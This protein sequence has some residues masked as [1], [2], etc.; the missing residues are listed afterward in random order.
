MLIYHYTDEQGLTGII[1]NKSI[2][3]TDIR[4]LND[5]MEFHSGI[6]SLTKICNDMIKICKEKDD[7]IYKNA[8]D[9]YKVINTFIRNNLENRNIYITSFTKS[10]DNLRQWMSYCPKNSGYA[11]AIN[12][13]KIL[14]I[15][16]K[17]QCKNIVFRLEDVDY[18]KES[19]YKM[20][21]LDSLIKEITKNFN[22]TNKLASRL[23]NN[24][25]FHCCAIKNE[26]FHDENEERLVIQ[27]TTEKK[28][29]VKFRSRSGV[30][31][32]YFEYPIELD[33]I[34]KVI[35]GPTTNMKLARLGLEEFL[36]KNSINCLIEESKCSLRLL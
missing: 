22:N 6:E 2:W 15:K 36:E 3:A 7:E 30:I 34:E 32:P 9:F 21:S 19:I 14:E 31:I 13:E 1:Q 16:D 26:E 33:Y 18:R 35:I 24:L 25:L 17:V 11:I 28:Q 27:S 23:I 29:K 12:K 4:F 10:E 5:S 8:V 20:L